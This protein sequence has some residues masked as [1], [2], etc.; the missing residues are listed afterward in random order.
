MFKLSFEG[1]YAQWIVGEDGGHLKRI[2][3]VVLEESDI[4]GYT[5]RVE[6]EGGV[7]GFLSRYDARLDPRTSGSDQEPKKG[8][9]IT[10]WTSRGYRR[11]PLWWKAPIIMWEK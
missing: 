9:Q 2:V 1:G 3:S 8:E 11:D 7:V 6:A 4:L 5:V 10:L